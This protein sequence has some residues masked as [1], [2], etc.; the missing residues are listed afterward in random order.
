MPY[1]L[2]FTTGNGRFRAERIGDTNWVIHHGDMAI[3][4]YHGIPSGK[5]CD[6][7]LEAFKNKES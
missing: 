1:I 5:V 4:K 7:L 2:T 3:A 6:E